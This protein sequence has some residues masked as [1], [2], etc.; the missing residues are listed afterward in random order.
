MKCVALYALTVHSYSSV[1]LAQRHCRGSIRQPLSKRNT[2]VSIP[3]SCGLACLC[4]YFCSAWGAQFIVADDVIHAAPPLKDERL[5]VARRA[6]REVWSPVDIDMLCTRST[7]V[8]RQS[9][10]E[11]TDNRI[12][13]DHDHANL[14]DSFSFSLPNQLNGPSHSRLLLDSSFPYRR[15]VP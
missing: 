8:I 12:C 13:L 5:I 1:L 10:T 4:C 14:L 6:L 3:S 15:W 9:I 2:P 7:E 11:S